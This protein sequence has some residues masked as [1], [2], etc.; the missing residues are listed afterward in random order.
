MIFYPGKEVLTMRLIDAA[1]L[2]VVA[3]TDGGVS[4]GETCWLY[5]YGNTRVCMR[6]DGFCS[7]GERLCN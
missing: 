5:S 1:V 2:P 4:Y 3:L 7:R 6:E